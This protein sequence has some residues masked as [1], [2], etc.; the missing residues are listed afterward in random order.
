MAGPSIQP[1]PYAP[2]LTVCVTRRARWLM[3]PLSRQ[4][5]L[6]QSSSIFRFSY[7]Q[8]P[9]PNTLTSNANRTVVRSHHQTKSPPLRVAFLFGARPS[10]DGTRGTRGETGV[11]ASMLAAG[12][13]ASRLQARRPGNSRN[14]R[15]CRFMGGMVLLRISQSMHANTGHRYRLEPTQPKRI[16]QYEDTR[17]R[18]RSRRENR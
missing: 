7:L 5:K 14:L 16:A 2:A 13:A 10:G 8:H 15:Q 3:S 9:R 1:I 12:R 17:H 4:P 18:H 11:S 6:T